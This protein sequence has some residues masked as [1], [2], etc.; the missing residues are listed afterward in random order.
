MMWC[1]FI[2]D[3]DVDLRHDGVW[4]VAFVPGLCSFRFIGGQCYL[5]D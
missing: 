1:R 3:R 5:E 2:L 4:Q